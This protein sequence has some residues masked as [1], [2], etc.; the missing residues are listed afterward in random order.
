MLERD[1]YFVILGIIFFITTMIFFGGIFIGG[2][3]AIS[4]VREW[5]RDVPPG[6]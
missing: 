2:A 3:V 5:F 6:D 1:G 4:A